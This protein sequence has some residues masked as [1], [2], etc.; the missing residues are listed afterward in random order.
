V[1]KIRKVDELV[2]QVATASA[3][4][5]QGISQ[6]NTAVTEMDKLTQSNAASAE[7]SASAAE[8]LNAQAECLKQVVSE[9]TALVDGS[10]KPNAAAVEESPEPAARNLRTPSTH[11]LR[12]SLVSH[13]G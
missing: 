11:S 5:T 8:E 10:R 2:A 9:L 13:R 12:P 4:Q 7:E 6:V 1:E 3:E